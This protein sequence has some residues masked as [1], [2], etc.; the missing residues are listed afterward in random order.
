MYQ[1][2]DA[3]KADEKTPA[4]KVCN[5]AK[6]V[7]GRRIGAIRGRTQVMLPNGHYAKRDRK[8]GKILSVKADLKPYKNVVIERD[9]E[10]STIAVPEKTGT[11]EP[12]RIVTLHPTHQAA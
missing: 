3:S 5:V 10:L 12:T 8:T 9:P 7:G 4:R 2:R 6:N 1:Y 11:D